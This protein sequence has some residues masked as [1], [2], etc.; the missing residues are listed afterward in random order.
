[1]LKIAFTDKR[2]INLKINKKNKDRERPRGLLFLFNTFFL[3]EKFAE[4]KIHI[5]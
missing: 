5:T 4:S 1:M 3:I 2:T